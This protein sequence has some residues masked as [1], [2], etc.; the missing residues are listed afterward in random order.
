[1]TDE[2]SAAILATPVFA[3][4]TIGQVPL[5]LVQQGLIEA[6]EQ[7]GMP[8]SINVDNGRPFG[9]PFVIRVKSS[10]DRK[11]Y[12]LMALTFDKYVLIAR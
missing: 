3:Y 1:M 8:V 4:K 5:H 12:S 9:G 10:H 7:W 6:F 2:K 11:K